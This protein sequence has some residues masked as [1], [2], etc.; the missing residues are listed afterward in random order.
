MWLADRSPNS[1]RLLPRV[2]S[3]ISF[4]P[5]KSA[6]YCL[7]RIC[8][9]ETSFPSGPS[10]SSS[11]IDRCLYY[12]YGQPPHIL[13]RT[14]NRYCLKLPSYPSLE[15]QVLLLLHYRMV[16]HR[17][18]TQIAP[19]IVVTC[20]ERAW[21]AWFW[22]LIKQKWSRLQHMLAWG[23]SQMQIEGN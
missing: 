22:L 18:Q 12:G 2:V 8:N 6:L 13:M 9:W 7:W 14:P 1:C 4:F 23:P 17:S 21:L 3:F 16:S 20:R 15:S 5:S 11:N 10:L 19:F